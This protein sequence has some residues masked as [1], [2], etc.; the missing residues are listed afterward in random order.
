MKVLKIERVLNSFN[1]A[2]C[3][4]LMHDLRLPAGAADAQE[5]LAAQRSETAMAQLRAQQVRGRDG[6]DGKSRCKARCKDRCKERCEARYEARCK[7][8]RV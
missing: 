3:V 6:E 5:R 4:V 8:S 2:C 7:K 1:T